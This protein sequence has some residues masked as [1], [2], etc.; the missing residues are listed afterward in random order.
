MSAG[1]QFTRTW[2]LALGA[3]GMVW[4]LSGC[5]TGGRDKLI[6]VAGKVTL[7]GQPLTTG[8]VT[9]RPDAANGN[10]TLHH[11]TGKIDATGNY[12]LYTSGKPGAPPGWY[13]VVIF[14]HESGEDGRGVHPGSRSLVPPKYNSEQTTDLVVQV[15]EG[16]APDHYNLALVK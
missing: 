3:A 16:A 7:A 8:N 13:R 15:V 6:P 2:T 4:L 1:W 5:G 14:A 12:Q 10:L 9:F 11:P